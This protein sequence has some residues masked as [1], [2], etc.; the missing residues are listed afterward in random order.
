MRGAVGGGGGDQTWGNKES[1]EE[2]EKNQRPTLENTTGTQVYITHTY[3]A[4]MGVSIHTPPSALYT[5]MLRV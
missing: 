3:A 5:G 1:R 2:R 4:P